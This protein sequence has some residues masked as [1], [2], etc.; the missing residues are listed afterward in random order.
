MATTEPADRRNRYR[1]QAQ[2]SILRTNGGRET[3]TPGAWC[4]RPAAATCYPRSPGYEGA[5]SCDQQC[6]PPRPSS[7]GSL[8]L[9]N[10]TD[11]LPTYQDALAALDRLEGE[12]DE[13]V[14]RA[15]E[16]TA[17]LD[18]F[19]RI[20]H[21][22]RLATQRVGAEVR[23]LRAERDAYREALEEL[24]TEP[25]DAQGIISRVLARYPKDSG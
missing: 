15:E 18:T 20:D 10:Q 6:R 9:Y 25:M 12:R 23:E 2:A 7:P 1:S 19:E 11:P 8:D 16:A 21:Q 22:E 4:L 3:R 24:S 14:K 13:A 5:V 17:A